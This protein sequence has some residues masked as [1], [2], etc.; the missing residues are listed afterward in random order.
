MRVDISYAPPLPCEAMAWAHLGL[1]SFDRYSSRR[2]S[3][4]SLGLTS[5]PYVSMM[6][7][8]DEKG[9]GGCKGGRGLSQ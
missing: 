5:F 7:F 4:N 2:T 8:Q 6:L 3:S 9:R 1:S